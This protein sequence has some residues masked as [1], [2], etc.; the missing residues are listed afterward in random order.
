MAQGQYDQR[1]VPAC[2]SDRVRKLEILSEN[3]VRQKQG[4]KKQKLYYS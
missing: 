2:W 3:S 1:T 4:S